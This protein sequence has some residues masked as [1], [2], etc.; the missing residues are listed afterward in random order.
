VF[1][2]CL[3]APLGA[4]RGNAVTLFDCNGGANQQW[5]FNADGSIRGVDSGLCLDVTGNSTSNGTLVEVWTCTG[6][7]NQR[8]VRQ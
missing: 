5:A 4:V 8:W 7:A 1:G 3:D 6:A 2:K